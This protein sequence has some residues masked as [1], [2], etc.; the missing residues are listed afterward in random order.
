MLHKCLTVRAL[1]MH[2]EL[3]SIQLIQAVLVLIAWRRLRLRK[4]LVLAKI[5]VV[6][7]KV[8]AVDGLDSALIVMDE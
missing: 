1:I 8:H 2:I 7:A 5:D 3:I 4:L 6:R